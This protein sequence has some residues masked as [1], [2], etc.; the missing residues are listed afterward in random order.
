MKVS[1]KRKVAAD[2]Q[3]IFGD[4]ER[5]LVFIGVVVCGSL[6][7]RCIH[8][9]SCSHITSLP[10]FLETDRD[11][12]MTWGRCWRL[13]VLLNTL[14]W[15]QSHCVISYASASSF[16]FCFLHWDLLLTCPRLRQVNS[17]SHTKD[18]LQHLVYYKRLFFGHSGSIIIKY[19]G[20]CW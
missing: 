18:F 13:C 7:G 1:W 5:G 8:F 2:W 14:T 11:W 12:W 15:R 6:C 19:P 10:S 3:I 16:L 17:L 20:K 4:M 9:L